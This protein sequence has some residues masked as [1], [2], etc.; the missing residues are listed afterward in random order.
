MEQASFPSDSYRDKNGNMWSPSPPT[1]RR[2]GAENIL[3]HA[4]GPVPSSRKDSILETWTLFFTI[5]ILQLIVTYSQKKADSEN[6]S[7][8]FTMESLKAYIGILYY[9]GVNQDNRIPIDELWSE[10]YSTFYRTA[11]SKNLFK[12]WNQCLRFD[13]I[14]QRALRKTKDSFAALCDI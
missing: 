5:E 14:S 11:M 13:D 8:N 3:R 9:R 6:I 10:N 2:R 7:V 4:G 12:L 1:E